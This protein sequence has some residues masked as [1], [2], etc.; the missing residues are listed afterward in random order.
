LE[1]SSFPDDPAHLILAIQE[2]RAQGVCDGSYMPKLAP[3]L[4]AAAWTI[5]DPTTQQAMAGVTQTSGEEHEVDSYRSEL[6]GVH[7]MLFGLLAFCTFYNI[8]EGGV[9]LGCDNSNCVR[10]GRGDW[11]KV[12]LSTKHADLI[13][14]IRVLK[15]KLPITITF[16]HVYGHQDD[17]LAFA[18]LP[19]LAQLN[20]IMDHHAKE[21]VL[22]LHANFPSPRCPASIAYE[23]WQCSVNGVKISSNPGKAVRRAVFGTQLCT[24]LTGKNRITQ[25]AFSDIDWDS[26]ELATD[27]FPP[28]YRLWVSKHVSGFFGTGSMMKNWQFWEHSECP[29]CQHPRED[30]THMMTCPSEDCSETW[31]QSLLG[32]EAWMIE[33]DTDPAIC[34]VILLTLEDRDPTK[35]FATFSNP[36]TLRAA[37]A[38][39]QIGWLHTTEGK[40]SAQWKQLQAEHYRSIDSCRSPGKWAAGLITN[41]LSVT[42]SQWLHRCAVLHER[43]V[44]GLKLKQGR[45]LLAAIQNQLALGLEGL[46][47]R[48]HHYITRGSACI[49]ALPAANKQA[50]LSGILIARETYLDSEAREMGGMRNCMLHWLAQG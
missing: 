38:Q 2:G 50:W 28:L 5:E 7:A 16:E 9:T 17:R 33:T 8:T 23:G 37:Q 3:D 46:H 15:H 35:S 11:Q 27:L 12:S 29:C 24:H 10:H 4:G 49:L 19:R 44:Q 34:E 41:L 22:D 39:D 21:K 43:D 30:K 1:A 6:Q 48:D 31:H 42:H 36:R 32:L 47:V 13:R 40:I 25:L 14:A 18:D 45:E 20:V 26:M